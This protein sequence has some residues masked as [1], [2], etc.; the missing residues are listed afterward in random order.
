MKKTDDCISLLDSPK[1]KI[2][3]YVHASR[4]LAL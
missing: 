3:L 1:C 2:L 4:I